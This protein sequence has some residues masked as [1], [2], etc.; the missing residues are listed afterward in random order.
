MGDRTATVPHGFRLALNDSTLALA[1]L[2]ILLA[3]AVLWSARGV[4]VE[5][6]DFAL[7]YVGAHIVHTGMARHLYDTG[8]QVRLRDSMFQ[9]PS[10][11]YF[12]HP[13][14]EALALS[15]LAAFSFR[16][17][18]TIWGLFNVALLL[19]LI[20]WLRPC[21]PWPSEDIAYLFLWLL[22]APVTVAIYQ[23]QSS[24]VMLAAYAAAFVQLRKGN[25]ATAGALFGLALVKFQFAVP[26]AAI[27]LLRKQWRFVAGF[28]ASAAV[29]AILSLIGV[30]WG[31]VADYARL[32][33]RIGTNPQNISYGSALDM[34]TLHGLVYAIAGG[35]LGPTALNLAVALLSI[36]LLAWVA[37][38]GQSPTDPRVSDLSFAAAIAA[39]LLCGSHMFT[40]DFSPLALAMFVLG[41]RLPAAGRGLR[42][43]SAFVLVVFWMFPLYFLFV[44]WHCLYVMAI[45]LLIF[46]WCCLRCDERVDAEN[47]KLQ[48]VAR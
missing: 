11:L 13:P 22:F 31:G 28:S 45:A 19:A 23:G 21:L 34:P 6:T 39:S 27:F 9:H 26:F 7:T 1:A 33:S 24:I 5:K 29:L 36:A 8:L 15:P 17:A 14:F 43:V 18:Y 4:N 10:P 25:A 41:S 16:T 42:T 32:L 48:A 2:A 3:A 30:G 44:K 46:A 40:H 38:K 47:G 35:I 20:V 37:W 12:E